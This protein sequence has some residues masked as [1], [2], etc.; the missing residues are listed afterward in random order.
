MPRRGTATAGASHRGVGRTSRGGARRPEQSTG[1][2]DKPTSSAP[3]ASQKA[4]KQQQPPKKQYSLYSWRYSSPNSSIIYA[5]DHE[6]TAL[7]ISML[8]GEILGF[9]LEWQPT[10]VKGGTRNPVA[11]VQLAD[12]NVML[13]IQVSAMRGNSIIVYYAVWSESMYYRVP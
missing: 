4:S 10:F 5:R 9:D 12:A 1:P 6:Q 8:R 13:L 7:A 3:N 11:L 2:R